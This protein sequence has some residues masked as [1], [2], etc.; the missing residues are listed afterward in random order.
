MLGTL[1]EDQ[2]MYTFLIIGHSITEIAT[3]FQFL[4]PFV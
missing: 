3:H 2:N 4:D 1:D